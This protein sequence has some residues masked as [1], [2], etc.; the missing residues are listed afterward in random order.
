MIKVDALISLLKKN[1][2]D[3]VNKVSQLFINEEEPDETI[4]PVKE[5][6]LILDS[7]SESEND[8]E[9]D[10]TFD[11]DNYDSEIEYEDLDDGGAFS[12]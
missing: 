9:E 12:D 4:Q 7:D 3:L 5:E 11:V 8:S 10:N 1:N 6:I 2:T